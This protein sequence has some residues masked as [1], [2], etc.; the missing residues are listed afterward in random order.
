MRRFHCFVI[1]R[2]CVFVSL[3]IDGG[4]SG[5]IFQVPVCFDNFMFDDQTL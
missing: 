5:S 3:M 2:L 1:L 4:N